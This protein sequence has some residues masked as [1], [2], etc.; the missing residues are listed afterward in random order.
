[1]PCMTWACIW[2]ASA[3][4]CAC[5]YVMSPSARPIQSICTL[6]M[7]TPQPH[8]FKLPAKHSNSRA[9]KERTMSIR[10]CNHAHYQT[11]LR[12]FSVR[13][14][15]G[16][17]VSLM[18][19]HRSCPVRNN[20]HLSGIAQGTW[21]LSLHYVRS[22]CQEL[23]FGPR[24]CMCVHVSSRP[25]CRHTCFE[26]VFGLRCSLCLLPHA[27]PVVCAYHSTGL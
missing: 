15:P 17:Y 22:A 1:M 12:V 6:A 21:E 19:A 2:L 13:T 4:V 16:C 27:A 18:L 7:T 25:A 8:S 20:L 11:G 3:C 24:R 14:Q 5:V 23:T 26:S 10:T 9:R